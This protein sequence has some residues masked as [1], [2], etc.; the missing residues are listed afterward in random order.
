MDVE[1][2]L[3]LAPVDG[4]DA[5]ETTVEYAVAVAGRYGADLHL[6]HV[7]DEGVVRGLDTGD[8]AAESVADHHRAFADDVR[9]RL[10]DGVSLSTSSAAGFSPGRLSRSPGSV[11][12]DSAEELGADFLVVP[13]EGSG[14]DPDA[15]LGKAALYV[16][17]YAS[18][19]VLSV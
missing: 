7:L 13:R 4:S 16:L 6:L 14:T 10:P 2:D 1:I 11:I 5:A 19:P 8:V 17:E 9:N 12:L 3:V 15:T 18:Q